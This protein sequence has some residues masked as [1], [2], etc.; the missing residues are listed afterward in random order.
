[1]EPLERLTVVAQCIRGV[2]AFLLEKH[3]ERL[4]PFALHIGGNRV[5][6]LRPLVGDH[7]FT[8]SSTAR[9]TPPA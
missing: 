2:A 9:M 6:F 1:M 4:E 8:C 7:A 3:E 5:G